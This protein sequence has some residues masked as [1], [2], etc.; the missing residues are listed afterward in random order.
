MT[1]VRV[2][3]KRALVDVIRSILTDT[4]EV[5]VF[6]ALPGIENIG[7]RR[8]VFLGRMEPIAQER[9]MSS[10]G[11]RQDSWTIEVT[12]VA[13]PGSAVGDNQNFDPTDPERYQA[14]DEVV[15]EMVRVVDDFIATSE[16]G[17]LEGLHGGTACSITQI[18]G[19]NPSLYAEG[20]GSDAVLTFT[21][22]SHH[23]N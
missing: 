10:R 22:V 12:L 7:K 8:F 3:A 6:Y 23:S 11:H 4:N 18:A 16:G 13:M 1:S 2:E 15:M 14:T 20:A 21:F 5:D 19:P 17:R 9:R